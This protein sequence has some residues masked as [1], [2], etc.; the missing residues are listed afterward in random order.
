MK[1]TIKIFSILLCLALMFPYIAACTSKCTITF[2]V[3]EDVGQWEPMIVKKG[4][5]IEE[6][7]IEE[8][9]WPDYSFDGWY[10]GNDKV[11]FPYTVNANVTF[12]PK[13]SLRKYKITY[14]LD[15]GTG[16]TDRTYTLDDLPITL[17][18]A[19]VMSK[20]NYTFDGW[21]PKS[22]GTGNRVINVNKNSTGDKDLYA[23][24]I[25][26]SYNLT[27]FTNGGEFPAGTNVP[28]GYAYG[29][30]ITLPIPRSDTKG[31]TGWYAD[32]GLLN[33]PI[34]TI[35]IGSIGDKTFW[36]AWESIDNKIEY[37]LNGGDFVDYYPQ[38]YI[39]TTGVT[40]VDPIREGYVFDGWYADE[41]LTD[42]PISIIAAGSTG[43]KTFWA[44]WAAEEY[45]VILHLNG[46]TGESRLTYTKAEG[47]EKL[48]TPDFNQAK[49]FEGW[50]DNA[51]FNGE[52]VRRNTVREAV[53]EQEPK[54]AI[55]V[56]SVGRKEFWA[57]WG[58]R[59]TTEWK[60]EAEFIDLRNKS[61]GGWSDSKSE[62]RMV[63]GYGPGLTKGASN[64]Y[65][66]T[67][68]T[69]PYMEFTWEFVS[70][71]AFE[72]ELNFALFAEFCDNADFTKF[73]LDST[74]DVHLYINAEKIDNKFNT[75]DRINYIGFD[76]DGRRAGFVNSTDSYK[77]YLFRTAASTTL[78]FKEGK[79]TVTLQIRE[80]HRFPDKPNAYQS[81]GPNIDYMMIKTDA[82]LVF[83]YALNDN[84]ELVLRG[85][86]TGSAS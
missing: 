37:V 47:L 56:N 9:F 72:G 43:D 20:A 16:A 22:D 66:L 36:A 32:E 10:I 8:P 3:D 18:T 12:T 28:T 75:A 39:S 64:G 17:P 83:D 23:K 73:F 69:E 85:G 6:E 19:A 65:H 58:D 76:I 38:G 77:E 5:A 26:D 27:F 41:G 53:M 54:L 60:F 79:N 67:Y 70:D 55:P 44:K 24:W 61:G 80:N 30:L 2:D 62:W 63:E 11:E 59:K 50:Y 46:G 13:W 14:H 7:D 78:S 74:D 34:R 42:G 52:P 1:K 33:G 35:P 81:G 86:G 4:T 49:W 25:P 82:F 31:F 51:A 84:K 40:L 57:K 48:P 21:F 29:V 45:E 71:K 15:G 68:F